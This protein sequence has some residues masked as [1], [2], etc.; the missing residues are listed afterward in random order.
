MGWLESAYLCVCGILIGSLTFAYTES[1][2][3]FPKQDCIHLKLVPLSSYR[4]DEI[5]HNHKGNRMSSASMPFDDDPSP[6]PRLTM[7]HSEVLLPSTSPS[8]SPVLLRSHLP[9][10]LASSMSVI[11][12]SGKGSVESVPGAVRRAQW[13]RSSKGSVDSAQLL[14]QRS[15]QQ[16]PFNPI[17]YMSSET[18]NKVNST[19]LSVPQNAAKKGHSRSRSLGNDGLFS[20]SNT[21]NRLESF[22]QDSAREGMPGR[23]PSLPSPMLT[24]S[25]D[26][27]VDLVPQRSPPAILKQ[28]SLEGYSLDARMTSSPQNSNPTFTLEQTDDYGESSSLFCFNGHYSDDEVEPGKARSLPKLAMTSVS[29]EHSSLREPYQRAL[30]EVQCECVHACVC[31]RACVYTC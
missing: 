15:Q 18:I 20:I 22:Y 25:D 29:A 17:V 6:S 2:H 23:M 12:A 9:P 19:H 28:A 16:I 27:S 21:S 10:H 3:P 7:R 4:T 14:Q 1:P 5:I 8:S 24:Q 31:I 11:P 13:I 26:H 30:S